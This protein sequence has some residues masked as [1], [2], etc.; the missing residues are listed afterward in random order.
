[1]SSGRSKTGKRVNIYLKV[2]ASLIFTGLEVGAVFNVTVATT[3]ANL[4]KRT[5][6][7]A[8]ENKY[9]NM[10]NIIGGVHAGRIN[11]DNFGERIFAFDALLNESL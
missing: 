9:S 7:Q 2:G 11:T 4:I 5:Q 1:M 3:V 10:K 8:P 6:N